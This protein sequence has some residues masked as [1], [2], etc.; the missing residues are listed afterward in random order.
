[1]ENPL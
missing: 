1:M